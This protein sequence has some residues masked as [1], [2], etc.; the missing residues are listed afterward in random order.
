MRNGQVQI[1]LQKFIMRILR[2]RGDFP[3]GKCFVSHAYEDS[4]ALENLRKHIG[5]QVNLFEFP[6]ISV[7][8]EQM[9]SN[10]LIKA[11]R[12]SDSLIYI[13]GGASDNSPWVTLE[14][15]FALQSNMDVYYFDTNDGSIGR[16]TSD[17]FDLPVY[18]SYSRSDGDRVKNL[19]DFMARE[20]SFDIYMDEDMESGANL[21]QEFDSAIL[22]RL[23]RGGYLVLFWSAEASKSVY[24]R[25]EIERAYYDEYNYR[26]IPA[27]MDP[28]ELPPPLQHLYAVRLYQDNSNDVD[29]RR[30]DDL[31]VRVYWLIQDNISVTP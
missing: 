11:I 19:V 23:E 17:P 14:R 28:T 21:H 20:R 9:V 26:I 15:N 2:K 25:E 18:A 16:D 3:Y 1:L 8:P 29:K 24:V 30:L 27:L 13:K 31:I 7:P 10:D 22:T 6:P 5:S 12:K 4:P